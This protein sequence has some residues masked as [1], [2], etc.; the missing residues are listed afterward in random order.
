MRKGLFASLAAILAGAGLALV[1]PPQARAQIV[2]APVVDGGAADDGCGN[3]RVWA[4]TEYL[5]WWFKTDP[6]PTPFLQRAPL[7]VRRQ[8]SRVW[9]I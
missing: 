6:V 3:Y 8:E 2:D 5:M 4:S 1:N 7:A 9:Q